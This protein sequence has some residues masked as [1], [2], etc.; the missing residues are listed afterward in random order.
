M[1]YFVTNQAGGVDGPLEVSTIRAMLEAKEINSATQLCE[2]GSENWLALS[3]VSAI[4][5]GSLVGEMKKEEPDREDDHRSLLASSVRGQMLE[6]KH[7]SSQAGLKRC[8][9]SSARR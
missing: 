5:H 3:Q 6:V 4:Q 9:H 8:L 7:L 1:R 2:E